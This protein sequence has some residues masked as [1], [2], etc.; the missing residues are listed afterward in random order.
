MPTGELAGLGSAITMSFTSLVDK[1]MTRRFTPLRLAS[2]GTFGGTVFAVFLLLVL[3][4][5]GDFP[6]APLDSLLLSIAGGVISLGVGFTLFLLF[7]RSVDLNK[8]APLSNGLSALLSVLSGVIILGEDLSP[9]TLIGIA[10]IM[11]GLYM[12][13]FFQRRESGTVQAQWLGVKGMLFLVFVTSLWVLG[14]SLQTVALRDLDVFIANAARLFVVFAFLTTLATIGLDKYLVPR[15]RV[16]APAG[17]PDPG[18][19]AVEAGMTGSGRKN[20]NGLSQLA[21]EKIQ[22]APIPD[23]T[24]SAGR[25]GRR[26]VALQVLGPVSSA[27]IEELEAELSRVGVAVYQEGW[28]GDGHGVSLYMDL[29]RA[30]SPEATLAGIPAV[31][32]ARKVGRWPLPRRIELTLRG[33]SMPAS[34]TEAQPEAARGVSVTQSRAPELGQAS[35]RTHLIPVINGCVSFGLGSLLILIAMEKAGLAIAFTLGNTSLLWIA[36]L[37][38][39]FLRER[40]TFKTLLGV[41]VTAVGV[42]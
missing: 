31:A 34:A 37:S 17:G 6:D 23:L 40:L 28:H 14:M 38:P 22:R 9:V 42:T 5:A 32:A 29:P 26:R 15:S 13:S 7:L 11:V 24:M 3:G 36:L 8:A 16:D 27:Q 10:T 20:R 39:I 1:S 25:R 30:V 35:F 12:L 2:L 41:A 18:P 21:S 4:K 19:E 33:T